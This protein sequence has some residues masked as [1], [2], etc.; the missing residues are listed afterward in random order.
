MLYIVV[1]EPTVP[2]SNFIYRMNEMR[3]WLDH[4]QIEPTMFR[5]LEGE[6]AGEFRVNFSTEADAVAFA[7]QFGGK[8]SAVAGVIGATMVSSPR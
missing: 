7:E 4:R 3:A 5:F 1:V 8:V 6:A 2:E